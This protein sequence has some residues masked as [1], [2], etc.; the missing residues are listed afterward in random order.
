VLIIRVFFREVRETGSTSFK[1]LAAAR[2]LGAHL[3][4]ILTTGP[5][6]LK[7]PSPSV[8]I[9]DVPKIILPTE[10][11]DYS[12]FVIKLLSLFFKV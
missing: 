3:D 8:E 5:S 11:A 4:T 1:A 12:P 6:Q 2:I 10:E 9:P 7:K